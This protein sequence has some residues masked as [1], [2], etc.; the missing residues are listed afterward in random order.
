MIVAATSMLILAIFWM[1]FFSLME[2]PEHV[3]KGTLDFIVTK[4]IDSQFWVSMK[5]FN[6]DQFG[7]LV[8]GGAMLALGI[9]RSKVTILPIQWLAFGVM[10]ICGIAV[11]YSLMLAL[12][13][14]GIYLVRV[15]NLWAL[16]ETLSSVARYPNDI[17]APTVRSILMFGFPL[18]LLATAPA[19]QIAKGIDLLVII[20]GIAWA[21]FGLIGSRLFWRR[22]T[23]SYSS[24]SS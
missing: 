13:T 3:R 6:F 23:K 4:P 12:M 15:D 1:F 10:I 8:A 20:N 7:T 14:L 24:A 11:F 16:G 5:K 17:Y 21:S 18:A 9:V 19:I 2:I 22:A